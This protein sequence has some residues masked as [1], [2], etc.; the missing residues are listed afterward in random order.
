MPESKN[1]LGLIPARG[2][3]KGIPG[4]NLIPLAGQ[5][6]LAYSVRAGLASRTLTRLVLSTDDAA[7]ARAGREL[8]VEVPFLRPA[9]LARDDTPAL[10]VIQHAVRFL[11][12]QGWPADVVVY[13]QPTSPLR[14]AEHIDAAMELLLREDA[15]T[16]VSVVPVP[17]QFNPASLMRLAEGRL[18]PF[19][20][21]LAHLLRRQDK[22][23]VYARNGPAVLASTR[24]TLMEQGRLYGDRTLPLVMAPEESFDIDTPFDLELVAWLLG[25]RA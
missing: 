24:A 16:V 8:G 5:P 25:R 9:E 17:H 7:I 2:G 12:D 4:K 14:R 15:D 21:E 1:I 3:S 6:L 18:E 19:L 11:E 23:E 13:L 22:P 10:P 20:P